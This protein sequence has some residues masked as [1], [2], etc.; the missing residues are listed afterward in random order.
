MSNENKK[1][2]HNVLAEAQES[3]RELKANP[4]QR[5]EATSGKEQTDKST[6][7]D[8]PL[9]NKQAQHATTRLTRHS[10]AR[11]DHKWLTRF[12]CLK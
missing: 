11:V 8:S 10:D 4:S 6:G 2:P 9:T 1:Q 3:H 12:S 5:D 7:R